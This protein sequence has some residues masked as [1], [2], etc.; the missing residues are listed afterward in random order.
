M[1]SSQERVTY[2]PLQPRPYPATVSLFIPMYNEELIGDFLRAELELFMREVKGDAER[3]LVK[4]GSSDRTLVRIAEWA[5]EDHRII[6]IHM[7]RNFGHQIASTAGL[8]YAS[9]DAVVLLDADLQ[10]A[11]SVVHQMIDRYCEGYDVVYGQRETRDG[12]STFKRFTARGL[13]PA[14]ARH[15]M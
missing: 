11:L 4:D 13:L 14:D 15:V 7:S 1:K 2:L 6:G 8:D 9:G 10:D 5:A 3:V 12:E